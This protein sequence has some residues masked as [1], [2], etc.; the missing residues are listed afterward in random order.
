[1]EGTSSK[2]AASGVETSVV[3]Y[4]AL[5]LSGTPV[6]SYLCSGNENRITLIFLMSHRILFKT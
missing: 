3:F 2:Q 1:M 6:P 4:M 5:Q